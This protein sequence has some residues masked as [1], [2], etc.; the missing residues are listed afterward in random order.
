[1]MAVLGEAPSTCPPTPCANQATKP[2]R[3]RPSARAI[4]VANHTSVPQACLFATMSSHSTTLVSSMSATMTSA[5][6]VGLTKVPPRTHSA[7]ASSTNAANVSSRLD[8]APM[9]RSSSAAQAATLCP[10]VTVG[11]ENRYT[12]GGKA[13]SSGIPTGAN[14]V[15]HCIQ[16]MSI[17]T[18]FLTNSTAR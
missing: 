8:T 11:G 1:M 3:F 16:V 2:V 4:S 14:D 5:V 10:S 7:S 9:L 6:A 13:S 18:V 17:L 15:N 12:S